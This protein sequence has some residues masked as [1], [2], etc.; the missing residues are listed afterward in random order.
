[1]C[2]MGDVFAVYMLY[3]IGWDWIIAIG[4]IIIIIFTGVSGI[5]FSFM[6]GCLLYALSLLIALCF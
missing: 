3:Y 4:L 1:M 6:V 5:V 2:L